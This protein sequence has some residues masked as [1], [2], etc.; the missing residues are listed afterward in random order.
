MNKYTS[1][2]HKLR[3]RFGK[4]I[5]IYIFFY[6]LR[7]FGYI[8]FNVANLI[9]GNVYLNVYVIFLLL[10][11]SSECCLLFSHFKFSFFLMLCPVYLFVQTSKASAPSAP[12]IAPHLYLKTP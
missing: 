8:T 7:L 3:R 5:Y 6:I 1:N 9:D 12:S 4:I 10:Y 2:G 11:I